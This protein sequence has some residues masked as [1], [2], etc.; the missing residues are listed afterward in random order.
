[1]AKKE[2]SLILVQ[3]LSISVIF[4]CGFVCGWASFV[5]QKN[6]SGNFEI[7]GEIDVVALL[8]LMATLAIGLYVRQILDKNAERS[9]NVGL[10]TSKW[11]NDA[12]SEIEKYS[13]DIRWSRK[14]LASK[15]DRFSKNIIRFSILID[16]FLKEMPEDFKYENNFRDN[17]D[18]NVNEIQELLTFYPKPS[19]D[20]TYPV[21]YIENV[22]W[23]D[24]G[25]ADDL[26]IGFQKLTEIL[27]E[28][29]LDLAKT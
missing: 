2:T 19:D 21:K 26:L 1:V 24:E 23:Y 5:I 12:I 10:I 8:S 9:V 16:K 4:F 22:Y 14:L 20:Q 17:F 15:A 27:L 28:I 25:Y 3:A 6:W 13:R 29:Q 18:Q 7:K 11:I